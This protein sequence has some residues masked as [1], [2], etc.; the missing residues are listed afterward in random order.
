MKNVVLLGLF[1]FASMLHAQSLKHPFYMH[2]KINVILDTDIG[3][4]IDDALALDMLYKYA[5]QGKIN[6]LGIMNNKS[7]AYSARFLDLMN[8]WYGYN[9]IP[10]GRIENGVYIN[11]YVDYAKNMIAYNDSTKLYDYS[12]AQYKELLPAHLLYRKLLA[13][14]EDQSVVIVSVGFSTNLERLL[15]SEPDKYSSLNGLDL[16]RKKVKYMSVMAG[17]F[18]EKKRAEFNVVHDVQAAQFVFSTWPSGIVLSPFEVGAKVIFPGQ[19]I[20]NDF[21]WVKHH[22]LVDAYKRYR[23][24]P[25]NRPTWDLTSV[26]YAIE[27]EHNLL[28]ISKAGKLT[29]DEQGFTH[30]NEDPSHEHYVLSI[31]PSNVKLLQGYFVDM[32]KQKP[33]KYK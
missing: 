18:G 23:P 8:C 24:L 20:A 19:S 31:Q 5:D 26:Y 16:V 28:D 25:Y 3:N 32:I 13:E 10:I 9:Q 21:K 33:K 7:S 29:I 30:F 27:Q 15:R 17:S 11:D 6:F 14:Q 4:D 1:I 2:G 22:P 12:I